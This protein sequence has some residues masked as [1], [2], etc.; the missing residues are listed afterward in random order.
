MFKFVAYLKFLWY[1]TNQHGVHSP[2]VYQ[3]LTKCLYSKPK[4]HATKSYSIFLK[5][6]SY[7]KPKTIAIVGD[8]RALELAIKERYPKL[9]PNNSKTAD[10]IYFK[11]WDYTDIGDLLSRE[12][13]ENDTIFF[14]EDIHG[15]KY[16]ENQWKKVI[17]D[18]RISVSIDT[19]YCGIV[20]IRKEQVKEH[21]TLRV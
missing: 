7:F 21:F 20:S 11:F 5:S 9:K 13:I 15:S 17:L 16:M 3:F 6:I 8:D 1:S 14:L 18:T 12:K 10:L 2:F 4:L 19:F